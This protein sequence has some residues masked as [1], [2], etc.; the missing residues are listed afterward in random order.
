MILNMRQKKANARPPLFSRMTT[1][2]TG[3]ITVEGLGSGTPS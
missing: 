2:V 1:T 3:K